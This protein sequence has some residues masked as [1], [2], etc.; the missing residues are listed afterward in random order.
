[1]AVSGPLPTRRVAVD[2]VRYVDSLIGRRLAYSDLDCLQFVR[3]WLPGRIPE[4]DYTA[5]N[6]RRR[7]AAAG[8]SDWHLGID[9]HL[10]RRRGRALVGDIVAN[11]DRH[12]VACL[13]IATGDL[14]LGYFLEEGT[15]PGQPPART[16]L[17]L[18]SEPVW[19]GRLP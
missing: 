19:C 2:L 18:P 3:G 10:T 1:M 13:G 17:I 16:T 9:A 6:W 8:G 15:E 5:D 11:R 12:G 4:Q 14:H 7:M